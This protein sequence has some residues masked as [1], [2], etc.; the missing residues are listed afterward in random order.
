MDKC[1]YCNQNKPCELFFYEKV[2]VCGDCRKKDTWDIIE[3]FCLSS[4]IDNPLEMAEILMMFPDFKMHCPEHHYLVPAVLLASYSK[5]V[6]KEEKLESWLKIVRNRA[7]KVPG[8]FCGT[9]G[10][11]GA[12]VGTGIFVSSV[13]GATPLSSEEW[14]LCNSIVG[15]SLLAMAHYGGPRCCKRVTYIALQ[16]SVKFLKERMAVKLHIPENIECSFFLQNEE[17]CLKEGCPFY[18]NK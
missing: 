8:A 6:L 12:A 3:S 7:E 4:S 13:T 5:A 10:S 2:L 1:V 11:C 17:Q 9:H 18:P 16:E 14:S 15:R